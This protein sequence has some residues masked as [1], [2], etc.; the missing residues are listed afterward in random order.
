MAAP[1]LSSLS[2]EFKS[3]FDVGAG[4]VTD[5]QNLGPCRP[6][7]TREHDAINKIKAAILSH[8]YVPQILNIDATGQKLHEEYVS[9]R[10]NG[11]VSRGHQ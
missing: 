8:E 4:K 2:K 1:G 5:H 6:T 10:I 9:E 11:N 3:Q 7:V